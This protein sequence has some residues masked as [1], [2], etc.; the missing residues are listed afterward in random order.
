MIKGHRID[1]TYKDID[2]EDYIISHDIEDVDSGFNLLT[3][4]GQRDIIN[5]I[6]I[7]SGQKV[8]SIT[9]NKEPMTLKGIYPLS[10]L[11]INTIK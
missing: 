4:E 7:V 8:K 9:F 5:K 11:A 6:E 2:N 3:D 1:I 10:M